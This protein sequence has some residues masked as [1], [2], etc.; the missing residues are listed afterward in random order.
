MASCWHPPSH[1]QPA[2]HSEVKVIVIF[3]VGGGC[4]AVDCSVAM[5]DCWDGKLLAFAL[6]CIC[7]LKAAK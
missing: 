3:V 2:E 6:T 7:L 4:V 5:M 1:C